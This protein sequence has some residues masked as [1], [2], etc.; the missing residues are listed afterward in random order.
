MKKF[1]YLD[2][3]RGQ[4]VLALYLAAQLY[5]ARDTLATTSLM[6]FA[7]AQLLAV[8]LTG[9]LGAGFLMANRGRLSDILRD[10][11]VFHMGIAAAVFL[12][13]MLVKRDWQLMYFS[14]LYC[15]LLGIFLTYFTSSRE[16]ARY[17]VVMIT[18]LAAFSVLATYILRRP[19]DSGSVSV[20]VLYNALNVKFY[21]F[22]LAFVSESYVKNRNFGIFREPGV[23]Q[24]FLLLGLFLNNFYVQ[25]NDKKCLWLVNG[26]LAVTM[27]STLATGGILELAMLALFVFI[28]KKLYRNRGVWLG[29]LLAVLAAAGL[30]AYLRFFREELYWELYWEVY[31]MTVSK[32][33]PGEESGFDRLY[34]VY[35]NLSMFLKNPLVGMPLAQVL[36][37]VENNTSSSMLLFAAMGIPAGCL[38]IAAWAAL[39][40]KKERCVIGNLI[41]LAIMA[42]SFNTQNLIAD[43]FFWLFPVMALVERLPK[44]QRKTNYQKS[45]PNLRTV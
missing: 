26:I 2:S 39:V 12:I 38:S 9:L 22:F 31:G 18:V 3:R 4:M 43:V 23:Y 29:I 24:F 20:P 25:W 40:W 5:F 44:R 37:G 35:W 32:F 15:V 14:V 1:S 21:N 42:M 7:K 16:L 34:S 36:G 13:P 8:A 11:R 19:V 45:S 30:C 10:D 17:Y 27:L 28:E 33:L 41:L 6:G